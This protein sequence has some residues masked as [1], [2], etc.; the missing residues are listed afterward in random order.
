MALVPHSMMASRTSVSVW[1]AEAGAGSST[2][3]VPWPSSRNRKY[4]SWSTQYPRGLPRQTGCGVAGRRNVI[5]RIAAN[6]NNATTRTGCLRIRSVGA[7]ARSS[8]WHRRLTPIRLPQ[9]CT[10]MPVPQRALGHRRVAA[11]SGLRNSG[12]PPISGAWQIFRIQTHK[13]MGSDGRE[14]LAS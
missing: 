2:W 1:A 9:G 4:G 14:G 12:P 5:R 10:M 7:A 8:P 3:A 6:A 13:E 11:D